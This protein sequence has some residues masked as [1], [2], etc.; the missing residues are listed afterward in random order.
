MGQQNQTCGSMTSCALRRGCSVLQRVG[1]GSVFAHARRQRPLQANRP[2]YRQE[3]A[4]QNAAATSLMQCWAPLLAAGKEP[5]GT[6]L[7][8]LSTALPQSLAFSPWP[9]GC[10]HAGALG[11]CKRKQGISRPLLLQAQIVAHPKQCCRHSLATW[12]LPACRRGS[13]RAGT[14]GERPGG[15]FQQPCQQA[16]QAELFSLKPGRGQEKLLVHTDG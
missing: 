3:V 2:A 7:P 15:P 13:Q 12:P 6:H 1:A 10:Q 5:A 4:V 8:I 16:P 9:T 11:D 14:P